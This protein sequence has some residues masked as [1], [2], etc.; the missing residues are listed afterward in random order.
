M[1]R[2][3]RGKPC[4]ARN[5]SWTPGTE[6]TCTTC[7]TTPD[8]ELS[9]DARPRD[10]G[11]FSVRRVLPSPARRAVGPFIFLDHMGPAEFAPGSGIDVRPH[12]HIGLA[13]VTYL[14]EGEILHRDSLGSLQA[15]SPG[16]VN[17]MNAGSGIVHSERTAPELR[18]RGYRLHGLQMWVALPKEA[19][20]SEPTFTHYPADVFPQTQVGDAVVRV[21]VGQ[22]YGLRSPVQTHVSCLYVA[23][24]LPAGKQLAVPEAMERA[25]YVVDGAVTCGGE[26]AEQGRM[27]VFGRGTT[28]M[29]HAETDARFVFIGGDELDAP[30]HLFWNFVSSSQERLERAKEDWRAGRFPL[31]PGDE[32]E[33]IP[34]PETPPGVRHSG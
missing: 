1:G 18:E 19:E 16:A 23:V 26:R 29:I 24:T 8:V 2:P 20:E 27:L 28:P 32:T 12:P 34:L 14:F 9:I 17:W 21:L 5:M 7:Q 25:V 10:L 6:P 33:F 3:G 31:V 22:A 11:G 13:T 30:R 15:I 4:Y